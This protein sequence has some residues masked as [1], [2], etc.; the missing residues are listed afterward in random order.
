MD[1]ITRPTALTPAIRAYLAT[2]RRARLLFTQVVA[3]LTGPFG[4]TPLEA[5]MALSA[6]LREQA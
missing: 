5:G 6:D 2:A 3:D 1:T 4:L